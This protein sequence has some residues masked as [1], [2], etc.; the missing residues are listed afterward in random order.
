MEHLL[1]QKNQSEG[2]EEYLRRIQELEELVNSLETENRQ[3]R[4]KSWERSEDTSPIQMNDANDRLIQELK[5]W[6]E[7][8]ELLESERDSGCDKPC[9]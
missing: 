3:M 6:K 7:K 8:A 9:E 4:R 1:F 2:N 5:T